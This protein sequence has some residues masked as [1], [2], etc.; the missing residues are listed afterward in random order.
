M[1]HT[2]AGSSI[3]DWSEGDF[4]AAVKGVQGTGGMQ[5]SRKREGKSAG[6]GAEGQGRSVGAGGTVGPSRKREGKPAGEG[7]GGKGEA[8]VP[9]AQL[10]PRA[11]GFV[12]KS[13]TRHSGSCMGVAEPSG[14]RLLTIA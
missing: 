14:G 9:R 10:G 1:G 6:E 8:W 11:S 7:A 12:K 2:R 5:P 13:P 3:R 4:A